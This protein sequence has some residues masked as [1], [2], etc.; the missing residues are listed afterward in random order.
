MIAG[1]NSR[2]QSSMFGSSHKRCSHLQRPLAAWIEPTVMDDGKGLPALAVVLCR[3]D[4]QKWWNIAEIK[5]A[6][7]G[8]PRECCVFYAGDVHEDRLC[9]Q[10]GRNSNS[11]WIWNDLQI[12]MCNTIL[13]CPKA[14]PEWHRLPLRK[15]AYRLLE[16]AQLHVCHWYLWQMEAAANVSNMYE[17]VDGF[18]GNLWINHTKHRLEHWLM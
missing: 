7:C 1:A 14:L 9:F 10:Y 3:H 18:H 12:G 4:N 8:T 15:T 2:S 5:S 17:L 13:L 16:L 6:V 11:E